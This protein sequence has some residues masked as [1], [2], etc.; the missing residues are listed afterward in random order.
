MWDDVMV[1]Q[2]AVQLVACWVDEMVAESVGGTVASM[3]DLMVPVMDALGMREKISLIS[4]L[5]DF[6]RRNSFY[7]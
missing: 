1:V 4:K 7:S 2:M 6:I 3:A 5:I